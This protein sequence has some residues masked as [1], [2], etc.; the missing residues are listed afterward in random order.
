MP[1]L[2]LRVSQARLP[3]IGAVIWGASAIAGIILLLRRQSH[4]LWLVSFLGF[5]A[6]WVFMLMPA[7]AIV[8]AERQL[9]LR[10]MAQSAIQVEAPGEPLVMLT[11]GFEKPTLVFYTQRHV[12]YF[13]DL[14][15]AVPFLQDTAKKSTSQSVLVVATDKSLK[16]SGLQPNQYQEILNAG[17]YKLLRV[18][19]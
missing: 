14:P 16:K 15:K 4:V 7:F 8:D 19:R 17:I 18:S 13:H 11:N 6:F 5:V 1:N 3:V 2:G 10:Q 12:N 9:P